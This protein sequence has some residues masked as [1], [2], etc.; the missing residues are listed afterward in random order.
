MY[1]EVALLYCYGN[2]ITLLINYT[3]AS[4]VKVPNEHAPQ[5]RSAFFGCTL[6][7]GGS[8]EFGIL[9]VGT[10]GILTANNNSFSPSDK[11]VWACCTW[12]V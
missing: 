1:G 5:D 8:Y 2:V 10:N 12:I 9:Q 6:G 4:N 7:S 11:N 3:Q